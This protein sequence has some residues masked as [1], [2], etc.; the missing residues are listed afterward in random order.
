MSTA[1]AQRASIQFTS[2]M[3]LSG[4]SSSSLTISAVNSMSLVKSVSVAACWHNWRQ[5]HLSSLNMTLPPVFAIAG[6]LPPSAKRIRR[7]TLSLHVEFQKT[8]TQPTLA[9]AIK[10]AEMEIS[11]REHSGR[12]FLHA[13]RS[14][15]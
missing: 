1:P 7:N 13:D 9:L 8:P 2:C 3:D 10:I 14:L 5:S 15:G 11:S 4:C 12:D 6:A